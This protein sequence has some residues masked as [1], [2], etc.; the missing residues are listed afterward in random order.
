[1]FIGEN[2]AYRAAAIEPTPIYRHINTI[3]ASKVMNHAVEYLQNESNVN[4]NEWNDLFSE[5]ERHSEVIAYRVEKI[6]GPAT[7]DSN[8]QNV[9]QNPYFLTEELSGS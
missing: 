4:V 3:A 5:T 9:L 6:G 7:G 8:T 2:N 1:M